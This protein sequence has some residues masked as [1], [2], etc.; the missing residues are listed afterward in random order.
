MHHG[1]IL[2][3]VNSNT[4]QHQLGKGIWLDYIFFEFSNNTYCQHSTFSQKHT[5][6]IGKQDSEVVCSLFVI[7]GK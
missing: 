1:N 2:C 4:K 3:I 7:G 5:A 6:H